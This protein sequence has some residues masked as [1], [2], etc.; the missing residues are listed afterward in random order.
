M[1]IVWYLVGYMLLLREQ[2]QLGAAD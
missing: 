1:N 2:C